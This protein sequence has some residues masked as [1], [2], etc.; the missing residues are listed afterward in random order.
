MPMTKYRF[1]LYRDTFF[2]GPASPCEVR[3][4]ATEDPKTTGAELVAKGGI[5]C[6][7]WDLEPVTDAP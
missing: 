5:D 2:P 6:V 7:E 3:V 4:I 1:Y